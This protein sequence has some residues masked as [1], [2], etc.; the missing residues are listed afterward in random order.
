MR[1]DPQHTIGTERVELRIK[2]RGLS[3]TMAASW[4][5][6]RAGPRI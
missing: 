3:S 1:G 4:T 5:G 6:P 2:I